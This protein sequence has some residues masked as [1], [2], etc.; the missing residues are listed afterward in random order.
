[1]L[2]ACEL[3]HISVGKEENCNNY[4]QNTRCHLTHNLVVRTTRRPGFMLLCYSM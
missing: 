2:D 4:A 3:M 1:M